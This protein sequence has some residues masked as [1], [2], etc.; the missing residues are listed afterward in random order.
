MS[1][2]LK[3]VPVQDIEKA[4]AETLTELCCEGKGLTV[5]ISEMQFNASTGRASI[6]LTV[7]K[8]LEPFEEVFGAS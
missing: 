5:D 3:N 7:S 6:A 4:I 8:N 2:P 1:S